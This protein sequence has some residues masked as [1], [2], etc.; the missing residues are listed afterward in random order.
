ES[1]SGIVNLLKEVKKTYRPL[2]VPATETVQGA[3]ILSQQI[4]ANSQKHG[5]SMISCFDSAYPES[6]KN[7]ADRPLL[8]HY[9]GDLKALNLP[10]IAVI[11]SRNCSAYASEHGREVA[12]AIVGAGFTIVS[13]LAT[14]CDTIGHTAAVEQGKP[15]VA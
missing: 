13:G 12:D 1:D 14:G 11:G 7:I 5:I 6:I 15:T 8:L 4:V 10:T 9:K 3:R 2:R